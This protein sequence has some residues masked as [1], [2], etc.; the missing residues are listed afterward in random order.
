M[1]LKAISLNIWE[2][3]FLDGAIDFFRSEN[4]DILFLQEV[5]GLNDS[6]SDDKF[7]TLEILK[8]TLGFPY[9]YYVPG[10]KHSRKEGKF[11]QGNAILSK[12]PITDS[13]A[14]FFNDPFNDNFVDGPEHNPFF[15]HTLQHAVLSTH[16]GEINAFNIHGTWDL[17]GDNYSEKRQ[18]MSRAIIE[19]VKGKPRVIL[20]G[21]TN[22]KPTNKAIRNVE[23]HLTS[24]FGEEL[25][26]TFNMKLKDNP[27]YA[28]AAVDMM[29]ISTDIK[30]IEKACPKVEISDHLPLVASLTV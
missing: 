21:D 24:V 15:P 25:K 14:V 29:F 17:D 28:T 19:A 26:T 4:A 23:E 8:E 1:K 10:V 22:A 11:F 30:V 5:Y 12:F 9:F 20:A 6:A 13:S 27:G 16:A 7:R 18:Q 3:N 2:G